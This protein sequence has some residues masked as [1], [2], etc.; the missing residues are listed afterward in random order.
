MKKT[1]LKVL[2]LW[3]MTLLCAAAMARTAGALPLEDAQLAL[4][5]Q[6]MVAATVDSAKS[7]YVNIQFTGQKQAGG[8]TASTGAYITISATAM[9]FY[10]PFGT[11]DTSMGTAGVVTYAST[12]G[13]NTL[14]SLC[15]YINVKGK[16]YICTL[17]GAKRDDAPAILATQTATDG[18]NNLAV[19]GGETISGTIVTGNMLDSMRIGITPSPGKRVVLYG[20]DFYAVGAD[21]FKVY[22]QLRKYASGHDQVGTVANDTYLVYNQ[23]TANNTLTYLPNT[24]GIL[25]PWLEFAPDAHVVV[26]QGNTTNVPVAADYL[27][28]IWAER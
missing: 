9:T 26:S 16:S 22:G 23:V 18:T 7:Q 25:S 27:S 14:G 10:Q 24:Y 8:F 11:V 19:A 1:T 5:N 3:V 6:T 4:A 17:L 21:T 12:L 13:A 2:A 20:C 15:D 28:C